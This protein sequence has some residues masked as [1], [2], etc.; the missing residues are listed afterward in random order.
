MW[1][2]LALS[3]MHCRG[4]PSRVMSFHR[5]DADAVIQHENITAAQFHPEKS[6]SAGMH[7]LP[8]ALRH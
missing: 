4:W 3:A 5:M 7:C 6:Q 2:C 8:V 1:T